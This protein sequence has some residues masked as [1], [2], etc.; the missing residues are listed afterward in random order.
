MLLKIGRKP[1]ANNVVINDAQNNISGQHCTIEKYPNGT[2]VLRDSNST[3]GTF[4]NGKKM[5]AN[6]PKEITHLDNIALFQTPLDTAK[7]LALFDKPLPQGMAYEKLPAPPPSATTPQEA[8]KIKENFKKL[9]ELYQQQEKQKAQI[10]KDFAKKGTTRRLT[11]MGIGGVIT[12]SLGVYGITSGDVTVGVISGLV[13]TTSMMLSGAFNPSQ[14]EVQEK[15]KNLQDEFVKVWKCP[16][17]K[18]RTMLPLGY[19]FVMLQ[20]QGKCNACKCKWEL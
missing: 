20:E 9:G 4:V 18:C 6:T 7:I 17:E 16:N 1:E 2:F 14:T 3:N 15:L 13:G 19:S 11:V 5:E 12:A 8:Q 10:Q